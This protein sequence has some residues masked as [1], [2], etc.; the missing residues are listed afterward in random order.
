MKD[1]PLA[2]ALFVAFIVLAG[3]AMALLTVTVSVASEHTNRVTH[4]TEFNPY[5]P[6][7]PIHCVKDCNPAS[8]YVATYEDEPCWSIQSSN[9]D[10]KIPLFG[11][12]AKDY[13]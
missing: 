3:L 5:F 2:K 4:C 9:S 10:Y 7:E 6:E 13:R 12:Y 11:W 8:G 1:N